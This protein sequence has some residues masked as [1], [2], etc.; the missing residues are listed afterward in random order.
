MNTVEVNTRKC[1]LCGKSSKVVM[2]ENAYSAWKSGYFIQYA[3]P[4]GSDDERELLIT[5]THG[6]CWN[7]MLPPEEE[8]WD[9]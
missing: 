1:I 6:E 7:R 3:W 2:P 5:G 9:H 4:T 8:E